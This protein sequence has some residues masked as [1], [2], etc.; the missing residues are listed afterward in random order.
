MSTRYARQTWYDV[1]LSKEENERSYRCWMTLSVSPVI[2]LGRGGQH[3]VVV[4]CLAD[5]RVPGETACS[6]TASARV[7]GSA[8]SRFIEGACLLAM[9]KA[10][11][12]LERLRDARRGGFQLELVTLR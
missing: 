2:V 5:S 12:G 9:L 11:E 10:V 3:Y 8:G 1:A 4:D 6:Y 7:G